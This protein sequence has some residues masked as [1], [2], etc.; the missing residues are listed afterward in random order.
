[1][2]GEQTR[3]QKFAFGDTDSGNPGLV[4]FKDG[5]EDVEPPTPVPAAPESRAIC[6]ALVSEERK[7]E[8]PSLIGRKLPIPLSMSVGEA[9]LSADRLILG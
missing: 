9:R 7:V 8:A 5:W 3:L 6:S 1:V 2:R 4:W